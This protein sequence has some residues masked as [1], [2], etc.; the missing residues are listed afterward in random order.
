KRIDPGTGK[1]F[2]EKNLTWSPQGA[3]NM[4]IPEKWGYIRFVNPDIVPKFWVWMG[5]HP[6]RTENQYDSIFSVL[7]DAGITGILIQPDTGILRRIIPLAEKHG[8]EIHAWFWT[9]NRADADPL[10]LSVN[11]KDESLAVKKAYVDYY[12]FMCPALPEVRHFLAEKIAALA[13]MEG[14]KGIHMDYIRYVDAFLPE[15][16]R[17]KYGL[18]QDSL[19]PEFDYGYHP[20][21]RDLFRQETG[22]DPMDLTR[23]GED[24][25]WLQFRLDAL[26][27]TVWMLRD[28]VR[29]RRMTVSAA[30]FP[31]PAI[32][33]EMVRQEW[34]RWDLDA[35]YPMVYHNFYNKSIDWI[36]EVMAENRACLPGGVSLFCGLFLPA[37]RD[38][39]DLTRAM[40]AAMDGGATGISFFDAGSLNPDLLRQIRRFSRKRQTPE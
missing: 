16:L 38:G 37:L 12:R 29:N 19:L 20:Y 36:R 18:V 34:N 3:V 5:G 28:H 9:M 31:T 2:P 40:Q 11:R 35:Y 33:R 23:P 14:L 30:V 13:D 32:A 26:N 21:I 17:P 7:R 22:Q 4:H 1:P 8:I 24:P 15:G 25:A 6:G 39:N 27:Q 10:W